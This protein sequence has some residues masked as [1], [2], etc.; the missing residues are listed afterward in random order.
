MPTCPS[1]LLPRL[2]RLSVPTILLLV[3][4]A[5][6]ASAQDAATDVFAKEVWPV[7]QARCVECHGPDRQKAGMRLDSPEAIAKGSENGPV[8]VAGKPDESLLLKRISLPPDDVDIMP[9]KGDPLTKEQIEA[10]R[11]WVEGGASFGDWKGADAPAPPTATATAEKPAEELAPAEASIQTAAPTSDAAIADPYATLAAGVAP[12]PA[13]ALASIASTGGL[14]STLSQTNPLVRVDLHLLGEKVTDEQVAALAP[15]K[16]QL[17]WL[18]LAGTKVTDEG[19]A[20]LAPFQKLTRLHLERTGITDAGL[21]HLAGLANLE[22]LNLYGTAV[23][24]A[25]LA[26]LAG[27]KN[28]KRVYLWQSK[29]TP[30]GAAKLQEAIPGVDVNLG[31]ELAAAAAPAEEATPAAAVELAFDEGSCCAKAK[32][33]GKACEHPC[34]VEA[35][36]AGKVCEKC[37]PAAAKQAAAAAPAEEAKPADLSALFDKDSCCAKAKAEGKACEHPCCVEAAAAGKV[38]VK[39]NPGAE[40]K[41]KAA[42]ASAEPAQGGSVVAA[43]QFNRDIRPILAENCLAC[44]GMDKQRAQGEPAAGRPGIGP[45]SKAVLPGR[46]GVESS[47]WRGFRTRIRR[48]SCRR[49]RRESG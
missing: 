39:C 42:E 3:S 21:V 31:T 17:T 40:G 35:A 24:D 6:S 34:C 10:I 20:H 25:G 23:T 37:N 27:L 33:E 22:Y 12:A 48:R 16:D 44:H 14:A 15:L 8:L 2:I 19:L 38:C 47:C 26:Q 29:A 32:A 45:G 18:N 49:P 9:P 7:L 30:E 11:R 5:W 4:A 13:D 1:C 43:V 28:L 46:S 36:A 41:G